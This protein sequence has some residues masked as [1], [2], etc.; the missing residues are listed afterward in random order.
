MES[1]RQTELTSKIETDSLIESKQTALV[2]WGVEGGGGGIEEEK[3]E[4]S[5]AGTTVQ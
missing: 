1:N 4:N 2:W 3:R 5:W